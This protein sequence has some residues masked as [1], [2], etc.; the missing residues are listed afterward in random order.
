MSDLAIARLGGGDTPRLLAPVTLAILLTVGIVSFVATLL[1]GAYAPDLD[2]KGTPGGHALSPSSIGFAGLV[3]LAEATGRHPRI[4]RDARLFGSEDLLIATPPS[5]TVDVSTLL[6]ERNGTPTLI[7]L[8]KWRAAADPAHR[9]WVTV[10]GLTPGNDPGSMLSPGI[11]FAIVRHASGGKPLL[12]LDSTMTGV[13]FTAPRPLQAIRPTPRLTTKPDP[14]FGALEPLIVDTRGNIVVGRF[15]DRPLYILSDPDLLDNRGMRDPRNAASALAL[16]DYMNSN[17]AEG[18][19]F[20]VTLNGIA[21]GASPL[22]LL[23]EPPFLA[24]TLT[25]AAAVL[26]AALGTLARFGSPRPRAR[27]IAFGKTALV[28]NTAALVARAG[29]ERR[30]GSR[31]VEVIR[32][33]AARLFAVPARMRGAALDAYLDRLGKHGRFTGLAAAVAE[34]DD[35][36]TLVSAARALH[37]WMG[38]RER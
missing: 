18:I 14:D 27:A 1:L 22:K 26:L 9:G 8:P 32:E 24:T 3:R 7:I 10:D 6:A 35:K 21:Q 15:T 28:D 23:F 31:Y 16:L 19:A 5:G 2:Q 4:L 37:D 30:L 29:A 33:A 17:E 36:D 12:T 25:I 13:S 38:E 34:A 20:D 11:P